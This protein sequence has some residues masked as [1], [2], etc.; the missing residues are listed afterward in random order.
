MMVLVVVQTG[1]CVS[2]GVGSEGCGGGS[3]DDG[4]GGDRGG[5]SS[6]DLVKVAEVDYSMG[7]SIYIHF[8][9]RLIGSEIHYNRYNDYLLMSAVF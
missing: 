4:R 2:V 6:S 8:Y 1:A 3:D 9:C 5:G 7:L